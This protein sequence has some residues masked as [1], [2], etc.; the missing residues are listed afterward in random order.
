[1]VFFRRIR[2]AVFAQTAGCVLNEVA[3]FATRQ[4]IFFFAFVLHRYQNS[5]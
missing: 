2:I 4:T 3:A 1:M 5:V